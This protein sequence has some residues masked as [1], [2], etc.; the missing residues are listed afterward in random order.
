MITTL[1]LIIAFCIRKRF[2]RENACWSDKLLYYVFSVVFT[3][4]L[5]PWLYKMIFDSK[6]AD[7]DEP[8]T[9]VF[10]YVG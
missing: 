7:P 8:S 2:V 10:P 4:L 3:P 9:G 6:I 1:F 5:G